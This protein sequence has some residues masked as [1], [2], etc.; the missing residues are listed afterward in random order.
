MNE[1]QIGSRIRQLR[2]QKGITQEVL[3]EALSVTPQAVSKWEM[4]VSSPDLA[5]LPV[6]A[7]YF[8]ISM[9]TLFD[10][11]IH[12]IQS[13]IDSLLEQ[14]RVYFFD[15]TP[16]YIETVRQALKT[17]PDNET[18]LSCLL[19]AYEYDLRETGNTAHLE[20]MV[21]L[22]EKIIRESRD[23]VNICSMKDN[24]A[25]AL[26]KLGRY[27]EAKAVLDTLPDS[28]TL[29]ND[30]KAFRLT[31]WDKRDAAIWMR[32]AHLQDLYIACDL[33]GRAELELGRYEE[34]IIAFTRGLTVLTAFT[35]P[36][37]EYE[38]KYIWDGMQTFHWSFHMQRAA[39]HKRLNRPDECEADMQTACRILTTGWHDFSENPA[40]YLKYY[41]QYLSDLD[42]NEY[43][44]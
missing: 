17:Y 8:S 25:A 24:Q 33:E 4:G 21:T 9:D 1:I 14:A 18:L 35:F 36:D 32:C 6:I 19:D 16:R 44:Q 30:A 2:K 7:A 5:L 37:R 26:L 43:R 40:P 22:S 34:A 20:E 28:I 42:M 15:D 11:D 12:T 39:C 29:K 3:A 38:D 23:Y 31:G 10:Y 27:D 13:K 41:N